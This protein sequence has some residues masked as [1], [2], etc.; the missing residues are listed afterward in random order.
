M[1]LGRC[2]KIGTQHLSIINRNYHFCSS[3]PYEDV[4]ILN[5][6]RYLLIINVCM[7]SLLRQQVAKIKAISH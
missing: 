2:R 1:T 3:Q 7:Y 5:E 4:R 6:V